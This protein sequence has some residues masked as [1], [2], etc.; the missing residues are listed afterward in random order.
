M[1][2]ERHPTTFEAKH[3]LVHYYRSGREVAE[4]YTQAWFHLMSLRASPDP[5][6]LAMADKLKAAM[7]QAE[8][9]SGAE[10][11]NPADA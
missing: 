4:T 5:A 1:T 2:T 7:D 10:D 6:N 8:E 11:E 9:Q 3:G